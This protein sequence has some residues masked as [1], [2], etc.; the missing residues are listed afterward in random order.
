MSDSVASDSICASSCVAAH[1]SSAEESRTFAKLTA[2]VRVT[3]MTRI[4]QPDAQN[5]KMTWTAQMLCEAQSQESFGPQRQ[6]EKK[7]SVTAQPNPSA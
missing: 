7:A 3:Q 2:L 4:V 6:K 1:S 5:E